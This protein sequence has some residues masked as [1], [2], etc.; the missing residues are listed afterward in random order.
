MFFTA[1][2][3]AKQLLYLSYVGEVTVAQLKSA[4]EVGSDSMTELG[5]GFRVLVDF[6][7]L[8]SM[9][10]DAAAEIGK[11]MEKLD[12]MGVS[13]VVRVIPD[14]TKDIGLNILAAFHYRRRVPMVTRE[15]MVDA[16]RELG[17]G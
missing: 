12:G 3:K 9:E 15:K 10:V 4:H 16:M 17:L 7:F 14:P 2:N 5:P 11:W 13:L 1:I 6:S 8:E